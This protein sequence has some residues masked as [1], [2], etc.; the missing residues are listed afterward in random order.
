MERQSADEAWAGQLRVLHNLK[1]TDEEIDAAR[2]R[3][4]LHEELGY[5]EGDLPRYGLDDATRD[6]LLAH[7][8]QDV[9]HSV[10]AATVAGRKVKALQGAVGLLTLLV[11]AILALQLWA[12][13]AKGAL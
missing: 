13:F 9:A 11:I 8:R 2:A 6:R 1:A 5:F 3:N 7:I 4:I 10:Y 12:T